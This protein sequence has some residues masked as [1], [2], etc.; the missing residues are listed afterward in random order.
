MG[1]GWIAM[2]N[3]SV[4]V[5]DP[6]CKLNN[7]YQIAW[8]GDTITISKNSTSAARAVS[9]AQLPAVVPSLTNH[10]GGIQRVR[11]LD[12]WQM[13]E[14]MT[15]WPWARQHHISHTATCICPLVPV[16]LG[17]DWGQI[18][19]GSGNQSCSTRHLDH[20]THRRHIDPEANA[21]TRPTRCLCCC[22]SDEHDHLGWRQGATA[23]TGPKQW[24]S[25]T[26]CLH[27]QSCC[28]P[29]HLSS[30]GRED[31]WSPGRS[32]AQSCKSKEC[33]GTR[34]SQAVYLD[35]AQ[36]SSPQVTGPDCSSRIWVSRC[37]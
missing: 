14:T 2:R 7:I 18:L 26:H 5:I 3:S 1:M 35:R 10:H 9:Q 4:Q 33:P 36:Y 31:R 13:G 22:A 32:M 28:R 20:N 8:P 24:K 21:S 17:L 11:H 34:A 37:D 16:A 27:Q 30:S 29:T 23:S 6:F 19:V 15:H 25:N 12:M